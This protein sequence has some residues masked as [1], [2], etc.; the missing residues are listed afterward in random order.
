MLVV[1]VEYSL[2]KVKAV[3]YIMCTS[4]RLVRQPPT[5]G[6]IQLKSRA[7]ACD[8]SIFRVVTVVHIPGY[9]G[10]LLQRGLCT[11]AFQIVHHDCSCPRPK[12]SLVPGRC[13]LSAAQLPTHD[14]SV[15]KV[16]GIITHRAP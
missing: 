6:V 14:H 7:R 16:P 5:R 9:M 12:E 13:R 11:S 15:G 2:S 8:T 10:A 1:V 3:I 4:P